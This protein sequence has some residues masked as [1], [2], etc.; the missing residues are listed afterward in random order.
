MRMDGEAGEGVGRHIV[1]AEYLLGLLGPAAQAQVAARIATDRAWAEEATFWSTRLSALDR[2]FVEVAP[3][4]QIL[5]TL[6]SRLFDSSAR[7]LGWWE[8]LAL[9]RGVA[10]GALAVAVLAVGFAT[11]RPAPDV[12]SLTTQLVAALE[13]EGSDVRFIAL[14]DGSGAVRLTALSGSLP[15]DRDLELWAIQGGADP[16]SMGVI[17]VN[18]RSTVEL[19]DTVRAGWGEGSVLAIT[20]E[21]KGGAPEGKPTGPIVAKGETHRI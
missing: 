21:P 5:S 1:V 14:Y 9:W 17:P 3:P 11:L 10:A 8:N 20:L 16:I 12:S 4:S 19:S 18:Q 13:E 7:K 2:D 15:S 6:E